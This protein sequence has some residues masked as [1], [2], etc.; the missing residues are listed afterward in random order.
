MVEIPGIKY[1]FQLPPSMDYALLRKE[2]IRYIQELAGK[3]WTDYNEHDPGVTILEQLCYALTQ[4][5]Y[6]TNMDIRK[7]MFSG[8]DEEE[9]CRSNAIFPPQEVFLT[10]CVTVSDF[11]IL[12]INHL[13][14]EQV[15]NV[16]LR[17]AKNSHVNGLL[18]I[19]VRTSAPSSEHDRIEK[20]IREVYAGH[21]SL[22]EDINR[23]IILKP[24][25]IEIN[26]T[27][28]I[29]EDVSPEKVL[30]EI[31]FKV[32]EYFSPPII[33]LSFLDLIRAG[34]GYEEIFNIS[35]FEHGFITNLKSSEDVGIFSLSGLVSVMSEITGIRNIKNL[36]VK[37]DGIKVTGKY[38][39]IDEGH[40]PELRMDPEK[41]GIA[42]F[43]NYNQVNYD[44][45]LVK[46]Y[47]HEKIEHGNRSHPFIPP[48][49]EKLSD[50]IYEQV[51]SYNSIQI[52][53]P[54]A[55]GI[56][57]YGLPG[58]ASKDRVQQAR[59]LQSYL[60]FFDQFM[61]IHLA[62]LQNLKQLFSYKPTSNATYFTRLPGS[63]QD[64]TDVP[65]F[66]KLV[67]PGLDNTLLYNLIQENFLERKNRLLDHLL[68]RFSESFVDKH[69]PD[70]AAVYGLLNE[71]D[72][73]KTLVSLKSALLE[74]HTTLSRDR[75]RGFN[76]TLPYH[77]SSYPFK[78][79]LSLLLNI[80]LE[81]EHALSLTEPYKLLKA[82]EAKENDTT[83]SHDLRKIRF[84]VLNHA[85][86]RDHL[87]FYGSLR[88]SY[89]VEK[90]E[91]GEYEVLFHEPHS[92]L[93]VK[94]GGY[95]SQKRAETLIT[96]LI[97]RFR[98]LNKRAE[99]FYVI[100]HILLRPL[101][102][103]QFDIELPVEKGK[104][105]MRSVQSDYLEDQNELLADVIIRGTDG[106]N[107]LISES[108]GQ[109]VV[110][111]LDK[112]RNAL[113]MIENEFAS[114][115]QASE[116]VRE[117]VVPYFRKLDSGKLTVPP[118]VRFKQVAEPAQRENFNLPMISLVFPKWI[119]RFNDPQFKNLLRQSLVRCVPAHIG[120]NTLWLNLN[121]MME[122]EKLY[123][124]WLSLKV[125]ISTR[126]P[127]VL[128]ST[129]E[130]VT[131]K[132]LKAAQRKEK[133][134]LRNEIYQLDQLSYGL[135]ALLREAGAGSEGG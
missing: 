71:A 103:K 64:K 133:R 18:D 67:H 26:A 128:E 75:N 84:K 44:G 17:P 83:F 23:V 57:K 15:H 105:V 106:G 89:G 130:K 55:Y 63:N 31:F 91:N 118:D 87:I 33:N 37:K 134:A 59:Q 48:A 113:L 77:Q 32:N 127:S 21:R 95:D 46:R 12:L 24:E 112:E 131:D 35:S 129:R 115:R 104:L 25:V 62:Q 28:D 65:D 101:L 4:L 36:V 92:K 97:N 27:I 29:N 107:Y 108:K 39:T 73:D 68:A 13:K 114:F 2:G 49:Q 11:R 102:E 81:N 94:L 34:I 135:S 109:Y 122:F 74:R 53:F 90:S 70:L 116:S 61:I 1:D 123:R 99:G 52:T 45:Y 78:S 14:K 22:G 125:Q 110:T 16:W 56:G 54:I 100:E 85:E 82:R 8:S 98:E 72:L 96:D 111:L 76:Y 50:D 43:R 7:L 60:L 6:K 126:R 3:I 124:E 47:Y 121:K 86:A 20:R 66:N 120:T 30:A 80:P 58:N 10:G 40:V 117:I 93:P 119:P 19:Y 51:G 38:I 69:Y 79:K 9:T 88:D 42:V 41:I 5:G 132:A